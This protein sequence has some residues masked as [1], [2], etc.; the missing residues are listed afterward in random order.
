MDYISQE[1]KDGKWIAWL[2]DG[3][4]PATKDSILFRLSY[5]P[6]HDTE[7]EWTKW[8]IEQSKE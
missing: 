6:E 1:M 5:D 4:K 2:L 7:V 8:P 3:Y